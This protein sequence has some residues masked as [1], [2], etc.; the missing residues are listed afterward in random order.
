MVNPTYLCHTLAL[1]TPLS[2]LYE[3]VA[4]V[5]VTMRTTLMRDGAL[6]LVLVLGEKV[7]SSVFHIDKYICLK[8]EFIFY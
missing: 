6:W 1:I 8:Y 2:H 3:I 5:V 7:E 4:A